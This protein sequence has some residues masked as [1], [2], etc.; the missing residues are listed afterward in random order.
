MRTSTPGS[1]R[2]TFSGVVVSNGCSENQNDPCKDCS[3]GAVPATSRANQRDAG[4]EAM[5]IAEVP[6]DTE[7]IAEVVPRPLWEICGSRHEAA[8][9]HDLR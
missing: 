7:V 5:V 2:R 3:L 6:A 4:R 9:K 8:N 1:H